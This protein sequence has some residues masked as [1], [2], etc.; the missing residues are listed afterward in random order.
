M[1]EKFGGVE[2]I[3]KEQK[4]YEKYKERISQYSK[5]EFINAFGEDH[6]DCADLSAGY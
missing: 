1:I 5:P 3:K 6:S 2:K 4:N